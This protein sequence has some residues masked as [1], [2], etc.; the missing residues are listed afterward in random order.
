MNELSISAYMRIVC[1]A[2]KLWASDL[3]IELLIEPILAFL[4]MYFNREVTEG[5][6]VFG[7]WCQQQ[8]V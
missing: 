1:C 8:L 4:I 3:G 2:Y 7:L 5:R 6:G